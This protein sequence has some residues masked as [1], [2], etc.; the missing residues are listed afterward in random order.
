MD[1]SPK[2]K[3]FIKHMAIVVNRHYE[4]EQARKHVDSHLEKLKSTGMEKDIE[5]L[6]KK[7]IQLLKKESRVAELGKHKTPSPSILN[8][9]RELEN[10]VI[11]L[12]LKYD[13]VFLEN[14][15]LRKA[16]EAVSD[17]KNS[18]EQVKD[19]KEVDHK[20]L[21]YIENIVEKKHNEFVLNDLKEKIARLESRYKQI[22]DIKSLNPIRLHSIEKRIIE[23]KNQ[24]KKLKS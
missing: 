19:V 5:E 24:L 20:N 2:L 3:K 23:Y 18:V 16:L 17:L 9:I 21:N 22:S 12:Q 15:E 14:K 4:K 7:I 6:Q 13:Q 8:E 1:S 11:G 10:Q